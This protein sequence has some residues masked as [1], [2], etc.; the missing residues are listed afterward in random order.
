MKSNNEV[1][2]TSEEKLVRA[3]TSLLASVRRNAPPALLLTIIADAR[4]VQD[5]PA[6]AEHEMKRQAKAPIEVRTSGRDSGR[7]VETA[8][9]FLLTRIGSWTNA[10]WDQHLR[11]EFGDTLANQ[12]IAALKKLSGLE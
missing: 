2:T 10:R 12:M 8:L 6:V 4:E 7:N 11:Y 1:K 9:A 3:L 5:V